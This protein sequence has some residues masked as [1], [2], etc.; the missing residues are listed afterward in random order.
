MT[1]KIN[2]NQDSDYNFSRA[3][4]C[5]GRLTDSGGGGGTANG[6]DK[7]WNRGIGRPYG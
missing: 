3:W 6:G 7:D 4:K 1:L 2:P 5:G